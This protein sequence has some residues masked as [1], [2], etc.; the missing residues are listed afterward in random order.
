MREV[1]RILSEYL[2]YPENKEN[3]ISYLD[4]LRELSHEYGLD[5]S[6]FAEFIQ[7]SPPGKIEE[8][9]VRTFDI[10][11]LCAPYISHH[12]FGESY[13]KGEF[14]VK[15]KEIYRMSGYREASHELPDHIHIIL[16]FMS[17]LKRP[18]RINFLS[19]RILEGLEKMSESI[20]EKN[21]PYRS[22]IN[23]VFSICLSEVGETENDGINPEREVVDCSTL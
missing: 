21:T 7:N 10:Y 20:R 17:H 22:I 23:L 2:R 14:M 15:L 6:E 18:D 9:Y 13:K 1:Y 4:K 3:L 8:E 12:L 16:D 11:P 19:T 5:I